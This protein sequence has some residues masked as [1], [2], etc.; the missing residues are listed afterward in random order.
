MG[1]R[2]ILMNRHFG[3]RRLIFQRKLS[4][5]EII[6]EDF[7]NL[8]ISVLLPDWPARFQDERF[9]DYLTDLIHERLPAHIGN[10]IHWVDARWLKRFER[11]YRDWEKL[12][13]GLKNPEAPSDN[14]KSAALK[15]YKLITDLKKVNK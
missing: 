12:K 11:N 1:S 2:A 9:K 13:S 15:I 4:T 14:L 5:G 3:Q 7:F 8:K 6:D 10:E